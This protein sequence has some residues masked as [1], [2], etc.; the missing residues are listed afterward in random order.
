[1]EKTASGRPLA[2]LGIIGVS[3]LLSIGSYVLRSGGSVL[4]AGPMVQ[5]VAQDGFAVVWR[6]PTSETGQLTVEGPDGTQQVES[7]IEDGQHVARVGGL[8]PN[9][10]YRY[11]VRH[12]RA[13]GGAEELATATVRTAKPPGEPV[14][15]IV[16][17]DSG[18]GSN[19]QY[20]LGRRMLEHE[21]DF[22]LHTGDLIYMDGEREDFGEKFFEPYAEIIRHVPFYPS[23]GNHDV[24]TE[25]GA[26]YLEA[27]VLPENG[28]AGMQPERCYWF[29]YGDARF[30]ALDSTLDGPPLRESVG[31]WLEQVL[32]EATTT[33]RILFFHH[34]PYSNSKHTP[35][36]KMRETIAS[37]WEEGGV[38]VVFNGHNHLY[39]RTKPVRAGAVVPA[40]EGVIYVITGAGGAP[41][42]LENDETVEYIDA[43]YHDRHSFTV[44]EIAG[45]TLRLQQIDVRGRV[46]DE[47]SY[48]RGGA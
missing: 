30:V 37:V 11:A 7:T 39:E 2:A 16:F 25:D 19:T 3:L 29:D 46:V 8:A 18:N 36:K 21:F 28:P 47:W 44:V 15:F 32:A 31:P 45:S 27:F 42:Y 40:G 26:P 5:L 4:Q 24:R 1:M 17:G 10:E 33:W 9:T 22:V 12:L 13:V 6:A 38:D 41:L 35:D 20:A 14:R 48:E 34:P 23:L 43:H